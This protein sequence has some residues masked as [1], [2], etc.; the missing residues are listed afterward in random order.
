MKAT[1]KDT[2]GCPSESRKSQD[3]ER[4]G[5]KQTPHCAPGAVENMYIHI[6]IYISAGFSILLC[7]YLAIDGA[8]AAAW[9]RWAFRALASTV[10]VVCDIVT[11][12]LNRV[13]YIYIYS[14]ICPTQ[15]HEYYQSMFQNARSPL[16]QNGVHPCYHMLCIIG[17]KIFSFYV[18][19][20]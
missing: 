14:F 6:Y 10:S 18:P 19:E 16:F 2:V 7:F 17:P 4:P 5:M 15:T 13:W 12:D 11:P 3:P 20:V 1:E 9:A 8:I